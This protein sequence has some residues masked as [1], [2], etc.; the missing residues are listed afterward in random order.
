MKWNPNLISASFAMERKTFAARGASGLR[1]QT[2]KRFSPQS[3]DLSGD[4]WLWGG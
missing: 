1:K 3:D 2:I 4:C